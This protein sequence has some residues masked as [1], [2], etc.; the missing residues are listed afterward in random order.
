[1]NRRDLLKNVGLG[2]GTLAVT[3]LT[4]SLFQS[5]Q[6]DLNWGPKFFKENEI[7]F[8]L[9][10][11]Q[12]KVSNTAISKSILEANTGIKAIDTAITSFYN[13]GY[14]HNH[15]RMYI[16]SLACNVAQSHWNFPAKWMYYHLLDADWASNALSWQ[17]V[18]GTNS[19][20]KYIANQDNINK[21]CHTK[22]SNTFLDISYDDFKKVIDVNAAEEHAT[23]GAGC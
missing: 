10:N 19:N 6:S 7:N 23:H 13:N 11:K 17:W 21:Y 5:C 9:K 20:K 8:D 18:A 1:M 4:V 2:L 12:L 14:L 15:L 16:A 3:P 22:Q